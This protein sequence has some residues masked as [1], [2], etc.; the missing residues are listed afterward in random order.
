MKGQLLERLTHIFSIGRRLEPIAAPFDKQGYQKYGTA[1]V[2][3][4]ETVVCRYGLKE[5]GRFAGD[6]AVVA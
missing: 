3:V 2:A 5:S 4:V 6:R 1:L